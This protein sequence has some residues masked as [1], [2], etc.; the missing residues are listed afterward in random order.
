MSKKSALILFIFCL[1]LLN[2]FL[3]VNNITSKNNAK[4]YFRLHVVA[5]SNTVDDQIIKLNVVKKV[6]NYLNELYKNTDYSKIN[7]HKKEDS[8]KLLKDN[9]DNILEV[10][11]LE[12]N[13]QNANY[14]CYANIGKISYE[15]KKSDIINMKE[16][17]YDSIQ[18][19]LGNGNGKNFWSLI[20]PYSYNEN[21]NESA[22]TSMENK[23]VEI[24][25][26][27]FETLK[28]VVKNLK[29]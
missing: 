2:I 14:T 21:F 10:A 6:N 24:K 7:I 19:I 5:N 22:Y 15:E 28:K 20:F 26:G 25:S 23:E 8:K 9:I 11:N 29:S 13:N 27:I 12:L 17:T 18:L 3:I 4:D 1:I 16:G